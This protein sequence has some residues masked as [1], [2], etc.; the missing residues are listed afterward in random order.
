[1]DIRLLK[2]N[3]RYIILYMQLT[4]L[5]LTL[6]MDSINWVRLLHVNK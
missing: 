3:S 1:M 5:I 2:S 6:K 4:V